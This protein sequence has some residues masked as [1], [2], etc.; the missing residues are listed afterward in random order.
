MVK[1]T[2]CDSHKNI[3]FIKMLFSTVLFVCVT[4]FQCLHNMKITTRYNQTEND[5]T[6][7]SSIL[8]IYSESEHLTT[9]PP[10]GK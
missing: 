8:I 1:L 3:V 6:L 9:A 4:S 7:Q 10:F 2:Q 5:H